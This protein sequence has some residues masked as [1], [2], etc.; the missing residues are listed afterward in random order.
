MLLAA[1]AALAADTAPPAD[2]QYGSHWAKGVARA[3]ETRDVF[4]P[5]GGQLLPFDAEPGDRVESGQ[6]VMEVRVQNVTAANDG[7]IMLNRAHIGDQAASVISQYGALC[8]I[9]RVDVHI[10][11]A[12]TA[13]AY[14]SPE[15]RDI[16]IGETLRVYNDKSSD[17]VEAVGTVVYVDGKS[18]TVEIESGIFELEDDVKLYR[19]EGSD[20]SSK[21]RVGKGTISSAQPIPVMGEGV[22]ANIEVEDGQRVSRGDVLYTVDASTSSHSEP[23]EHT[24]ICPVDGM[25]S[26]VYVQPGQSVA[27][28]Q[29]LFSCQPLDD[30]EFVVDVDEYDLSDIYLGKMLKV[31]VDAYGTTLIDAQVTKIVPLGTA[32][33]DTTKYPVHLSPTSSEFEILPGMHLT[34]YWD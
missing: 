1:P 27:K 9:D 33:L 26:A 19:G 21:E 28:D 10:V 23:A 20:Y 4:A 24:A 2:S 15:N 8:Y 30:I 31:K 16:T 3:T 13:G 12:T 22:I 32:V 18:F 34:A 11:V 5:I 29:L 25:I 6:T 7:V 14:D 17:P